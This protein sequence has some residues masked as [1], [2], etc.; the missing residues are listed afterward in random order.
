MNNNE[1]KNLITELENVL[2][3]NTEDIDIEQKPMFDISVGVGFLVRRILSASDAVGESPSTI[4]KSVENLLEVACKGA[5][6]IKQQ[7]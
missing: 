5:E 2:N 4:L 1:F 6:N 7:N 3:N